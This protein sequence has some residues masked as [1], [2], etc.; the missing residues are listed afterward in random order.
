VTRR[1]VPL[2][3]TLSLIWGASY[4]F[5]K[6]AVGD[7]SPATMMFLRL[8]VASLL[9]HAFLYATGGRAVTAQLRAAW[10]PGLVLGVI[11]G[12]LPFT[13]IAWGELHV[14]SGV[15][16]VGNSA[17]PIFNAGLAVWLLPSERVNGTRLAGL[18]LGLVGVGV[19]AGFDSNGGDSLAL[20]GTLAVLGSSVSYAASGLFAQKRVARTTGPVLAASSTLFGA[21][22]LLPLAVVSPPTHA[23]GWKAVASLAALTVLG[24]AFAQL[25][26]YRMIRLH[27]SARTSL[28]TY[29]MPIMALGYGALLLDEPITEPIV[30]ALGLILAGVAIGSGGLRLTRLR[31]AVD[32]A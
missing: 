7:F 5:I 18:L 16:A 32:P 3:V 27:G 26:L 20:V 29:L 23:P 22:V 30:A 11:N 8:L 2:L 15:A 28:V 25:V 14:A 13:L 10:R 21:L 6:E 4:L 17:V 24:T 1:Y 9:L 19:L 12:A 31:R